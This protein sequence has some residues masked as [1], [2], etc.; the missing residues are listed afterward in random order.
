MKQLKMDAL[1]KGSV[2]QEKLICNP[3]GKGKSCAPDRSS[4]VSWGRYYGV[5]SLLWYRPEAL[6]LIPSTFQNIIFAFNA[7]K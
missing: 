4:E 3:S 5:V 1:S 2:G 7:S 6:D